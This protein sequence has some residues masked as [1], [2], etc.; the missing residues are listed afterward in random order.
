MNSNKTTITINDPVNIKERKKVKLIHEELFDKYN[1]DPL[2]LYSINDK[3][4]SIPREWIIEMIRDNINNSLIKPLSI[5]FNDSEN[6]FFIGFDSYDKTEKFEKQFVIN[7][8][9]IINNYITRKEEKPEDYKRDIMYG[10]KSEGMQI[11]INCY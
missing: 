8:F 3:Q 1:I 9:K 11:I 7:M 5:D 2:K 4:K 6:L 10:I